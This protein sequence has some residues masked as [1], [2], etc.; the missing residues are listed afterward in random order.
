MTDGQYP[1][2]VDLSN[3]EVAEKVVNENLRL[4][5]PENCPNELWHIVTSCWDL[6]DKRP[7][8][9]QLF[10]SLNKFSS[11]VAPCKIAPFLVFFF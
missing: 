3:Q 11:T 6:P 9:K 10:Q 5:K 8:F 7:T 1:Y 2:T 4:P